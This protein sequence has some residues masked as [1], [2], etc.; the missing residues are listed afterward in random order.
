MAR[1]KTAIVILMLVLLVLILGF[2]VI[3]AFVLKPV[4]SGYAIKAQNFGTE[5]TIL[6]IAQLSQ[7]CQVVPLTIGEQTIELIDVNCVQKESEILVE[8]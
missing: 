3:Y 6:T 7:N 1:N 2:L 8:N 4:V 5:Q